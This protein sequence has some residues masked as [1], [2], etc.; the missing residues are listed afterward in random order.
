MALI[1]ST[2]LSTRQVSLE[3]Y[4][5]VVWAA[6]PLKR[7]HFSCKKTLLSD[8]SFGVGVTCDPFTDRGMLSYRD[9]ILT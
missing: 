7:S 9:V 5:P 6:I 1:L 2:V 4:M 3:G 8:L